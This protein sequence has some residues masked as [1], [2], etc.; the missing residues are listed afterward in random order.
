MQKLERRKVVAELLQ[1]RGDLL[2]IAGLGSAAYDVASVD[3]EPTNFPSW[4]AMGGTVMMGMG[5]AL[6][7]P[8]R[9]VLVL[10]GDGDALMGMGS[11]ATVALQDPKNLRIV[12]LDNEQFGETGHQTT[13]TA[14]VANLAAIAQGCGIEDAK[15]ITTMDD[16]SALRDAI[17]ADE[18]P[19]LAVIKISSD[20]VP[21]V[22]PPR[23]GPYLANRFRA[24]LLGE[25]EAHLA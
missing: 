17:H 10:T 14:T 3:N 19:L 6:A 24:A 5:V 13:H 20:E 22:L 21:R 25:D 12:V 8:E 4:G 11:F 7:Q 16:V 15:T 2:V 18:G 1:E 9:N 23:D